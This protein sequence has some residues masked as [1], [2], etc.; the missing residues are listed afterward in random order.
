MELHRFLKI[1]AAHV[2]ERADFDDAGVIDQ[3]IKGAEV[4]DDRLDR[5]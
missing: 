3:N 1:V 5:A 4:I 2:L